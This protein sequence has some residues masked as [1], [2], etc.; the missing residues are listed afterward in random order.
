MDVSKILTKIL[1]EQ[2]EQENKSK[3]TGIN[4]KDTE[5]VLNSVK[6]CSTLQY[7]GGIKQ[8]SP[9]F[10]IDGITKAPLISKFTEL[11]N[12][13]PSAVAYATG[14]KGEETI[15][16]FGI[17]DPNTQSG[18]RGLLGYTITKGQSPQILPNGAGAG[19]PELQRFE[20]VGKVP[21]SD[22]DKAIVDSMYGKFGVLYDTPD[23]NQMGNYEKVLL[24]DI[25]GIQNPRDGFI[26]VQKSAALQ[27]FRNT[28]VDV[29]NDLITQGF[30]AT[31]PPQN[32]GG[33]FGFSLGM[34]QSNV[35]RGGKPMDYYWVDANSPDAPSL[36]PDR[37]TCRTAI[38]KLHG[39]MRQ[40]LKR[41]ATSTECDIDVVKN[42]FTALRCK[43]KNFIGGPIGLGNEFEELQKD[44]TTPFGLRRMSLANIA[45]KI[46][47]VT[48][49]STIELKINKFLNEEHN[50]FSFVKNKQPK[51]DQTV[52]ENL[53]TQLVLS[54]YFDLQKSLKKVNRLNENIFGDIM[55]G[56]GSNLGDK[57]IQGGKEA[58]ASRI[59]S[60]LGFDQNSY[61]SLLLI[62]L[63]ANLEFKDYANILS[64]CKKYTSVIVKSALEAWLDMAA[65]KMGGGAMEGFVYSALKNTVT[66]TAAQSAVFKKLEKLASSMV[67]P[68][69]E[70]LSGGVKDGSLKLF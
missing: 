27:K 61:I 48:N 28:N 50:K 56:L 55:G 33:K 40:E 21:L 17:V 62:N 24:K 38:K 57:L 39:C 42:K 31:Q 68:I 51:F 32:Q 54:A 25:P 29:N 19:C 59:I 8:M 7:L 1:L 34:V 70:G 15:V 65:K 12:M 53:S 67:C 66:E 3:A 64:D 63:F 22:Y 58:I 2:V 16:V 41:G 4:Y 43:T 36:D 6:S 35:G 5:E 20:D 47:G 44:V 52:V 9:T 23:K 60:Y 30:T 26:W 69:I 37:E 14:K 45:P 18:K 13:N 11:K 46:P 49:E 10:P